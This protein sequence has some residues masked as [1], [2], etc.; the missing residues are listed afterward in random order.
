[1]G[2]RT[3]KNKLRQLSDLDGIGPAMLRDFERLKIR[4]VEQLA[5]ANPERLYE[6]LAELDGRA[7]DVCVLDVFRCAVAQARNPRLP[8]AQRNWWYWSRQR[9]KKETANERR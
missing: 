5:R 1:M 8:A 9:K 7:H 4:T 2:E 6:R 3:A